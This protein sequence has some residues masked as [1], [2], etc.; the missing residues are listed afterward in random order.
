MEILV[1]DK[2]YNSETNDYLRV[3]FNNLKEYNIILMQDLNESLALYKSKSF[4][5]ILI[6]FTTK[7]GKAFLQEI[8]RLNS[9]QKI[10]TMG[11]TLSCS[12]EMGCSYCLENFH[13]RRLIKPINSIELYKTISEFEEINCKY[14]HAFEN[15]KGLIKELIT[16][17]NYFSFDE[18]NGI[19][20]SM[21][22]DIQELKQ[23]L[24]LM[25]DLKAYNIDFKVIDDKSIKVL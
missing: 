14:A 19:I 23:L 16:R 21:N 25:V 12:S 11:Y 8:N 5:I 7:C 9:L 24:N 4:H 22:N 3:L 10:I 18:E 15:P 13:K 1:F 17:Y 6:D 2:E 20:F